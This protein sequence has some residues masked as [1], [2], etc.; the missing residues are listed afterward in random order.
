MIYIPPNICR[1]EYGR[2]VRLTILI[3]STDLCEVNNICA[4]FRNEKGKEDQPSSPSLSLTYLSPGEVESHLESRPPPA[5]AVVVRPLLPAP[6]PPCRSP[7]SCWARVWGP[8]LRP[9]ERHLRDRVRA[10][11]V[12]KTFLVI[13]KAD[14]SEPL[15]YGNGQTLRDKKRD[16]FA[17][18]FLEGYD[19]MEALRTGERRAEGGNL[20]GA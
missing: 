17:G 9:T 15:L 16:L 13:Q 1:I 11:K 5:A 12:G 20:V 7:G 18:N 2:I 14:Q 10:N 4:K 8:P 19:A 3:F 6:S